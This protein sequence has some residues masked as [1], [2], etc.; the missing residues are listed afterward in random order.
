M[1]LLK[2][3]PKLKEKNL[4]KKIKKLLKKKK[5]LNLQFKTPSKNLNQPNK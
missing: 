2:S 1:R 4:K 3:F 5:L